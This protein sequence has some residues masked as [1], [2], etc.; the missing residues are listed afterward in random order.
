MANVI[1]PGDLAGLP[2]KAREALE[3]LDD[4]VDGSV[5]FSRGFV[6]HTDTAAKS[7]FTLPANAFLLDLVV[8][9]ETAFNDSGTDLLDIG[10]LGTGNHYVNDLSVVAAGKGA[11]TITNLGDVGANGVTVVGTYIGQN[12][13]ASAG[14][15]WVTALWTPQAA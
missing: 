4:A 2:P 15:A 11:P 6:L 10:K 13:N 1:K 5:H 7:L 3:R 12:S 9:V 14:K 8:F